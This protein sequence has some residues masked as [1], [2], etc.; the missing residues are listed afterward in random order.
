MWKHTSEVVGVI[1]HSLEEIEWHFTQREIYPK[2]SG[3]SKSL[4]FHIINFRFRV[5]LNSNMKNLH[6]HSKFYF[7]QTFKLM[8]LEIW[9]FKAAC[10]Q[11]EKLLKCSYICLWTLSMHTIEWL[12]LLNPRLKKK[13]AQI[14][15]K[16]FSCLNDQFQYLCTYKPQ[17]L[18]TTILWYS[19]LVSIN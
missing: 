11:T 10:C 9:V 13:S 3:I 15:M 6:L 19:F 2:F 8:K 5:G 17:F 12:K 16:K 14:Y 1:H 18:E 7:M 4:S